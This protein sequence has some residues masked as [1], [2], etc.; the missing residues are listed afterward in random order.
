[1]N[2]TR[3]KLF[4]DTPGAV[5]VAPSLFTHVSAPLVPFEAEQLHRRAI[6]GFEVQLGPQHP[7]TLSAVN[8]LAL[9]LQ[10]QGK[11]E[12]ARPFFFFIRH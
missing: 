9:L 11:L 8:N 3:C 1:M 2:S 5:T 6:A 4:D 12:E 10:K 7:H